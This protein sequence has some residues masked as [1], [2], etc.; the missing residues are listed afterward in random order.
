MKT[1]ENEINQK[2]EYPISNLGAV[3][4][5]VTD[6]QN[7]LL[8]PPGD[9]VALTKALTRLVEDP[10]LR[11]RL[12][13]AAKAVHRERLEIAPFAMALQR[14]WRDALIGKRREAR[15]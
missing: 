5:I 2:L 10:A 8:V 6:E 12:G 9:V 11:T 4:D 1:I 13:E 3:E 7:G 15:S 14:V